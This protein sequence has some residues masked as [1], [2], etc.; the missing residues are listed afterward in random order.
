MDIVDVAVASSPVVTFPSIKRVVR[1]LGP[2]FGFLGPSF[3]TL[4]RHILHNTRQR[5]RD[6]TFSGKQ[7]PARRMCCGRS[8]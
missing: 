5:S 1:I 7:D 2:A 6:E 8:S 3:G 4:T